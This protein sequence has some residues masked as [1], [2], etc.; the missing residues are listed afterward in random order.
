MFLF[1]CQYSMVRV[2]GRLFIYHEI[3]I[4]NNSHLL[5]VTLTERSKNLRQSYVLVR[6]GCQS[7]KEV[8]SK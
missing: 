3:E 6:V 4:I 8:W 7:C 1:L 5:N 2:S